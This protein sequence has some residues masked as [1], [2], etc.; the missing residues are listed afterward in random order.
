MPDQSR[1]VF[2]KK[3]KNIRITNTNKL[4]NEPFLHKTFQYEVSLNRPLTRQEAIHLV[5]QA[6]MALNQWLIEE[7]PIKRDGL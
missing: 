5:Q 1:Y 3:K 6:Q 2:Y 7:I 4:F